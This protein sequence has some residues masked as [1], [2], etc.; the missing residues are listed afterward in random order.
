MKRTMM[1]LAVTGL[2]LA[3]ATA[4]FSAA[5]ERTVFRTEPWT[6]I[7]QGGIHANATGSVVVQ[8]TKGGGAQVT[9]QLQ[10]AAPRYTYVVKSKGQVLGKFT[11]NAKGT[12]G[13]EIFVA[14]ANPDTG[15][16]G[17][18]IN[19]WQTAGEFS[20]YWGAPPDGTYDD[21]NAWLANPDP[22]KDDFPGLGLLWGP[23]W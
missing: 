5:S 15:P 14:D 12:G 2:V 16:L 10:K 8:T 20:S 4:A 7:V 1:Q 22:N 6:A 17:R 21:W 19:I 13:L 23:R 3:C 18:F 9:V 11:T